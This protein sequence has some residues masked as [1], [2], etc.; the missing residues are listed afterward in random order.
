[1]SHTLRKGALTLSLLMTTQ[2]VFVDRVDKDQT[3]QNVQSDH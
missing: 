2:G 3:A 1:M